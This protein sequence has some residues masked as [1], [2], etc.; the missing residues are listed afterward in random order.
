[1]FCT[2]CGQKISEDDVFC[3]FC[4]EKVIPD[5][6][7]AD[8]LNPVDGTDKREEVS[9]DDPESAVS[10]STTENYSVSSDSAQYSQ[11]SVNT[12]IHAPDKPKK[13]RRPIVVAIIIAAVVVFVF[14]RWNQITEQKA[15]LNEKAEYYSYAKEAVLSEV[16][17][18]PSTAV[19]P[20]FKAEFVSDDTQSVNYDGKQY[21]TRIVSSYVY[22]NDASGNQQKLQYQIKIGRCSNS[23]DDDGLYYY[24]VIYAE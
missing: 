10:G 9:K 21:K 19:F 23:D 16:L 4:G 22:A 6:T 24:E 15:I 11:P 17:L 8:I 5:E 2:N 14:V 20:D 1:M 13:S 18:Y 7:Q 3:P 12:A